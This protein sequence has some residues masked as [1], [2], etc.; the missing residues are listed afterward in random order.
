MSPF[1]GSSGKAG[2]AA[3][4]SFEQEVKRYLQR[5]RIRFTDNTTSYKKPDFTLHLAAEQRFFLEVKEKQKPYDP[6]NWP[7]FAPERDLLILDDLTVR[8]CLG[9]A[10]RAG[11]MVRDSVQQI[12]VFFSVVDLAL[13]PKLRVNRTIARQVQ[14]LKGKWLINLRNGERAPSV[15]QCFTHLQRYLQ[16]LPVILFEHHPCYGRYAGEELGSGGITR[17]PGHWDTDVRSTR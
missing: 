14:D 15:E 8:K 17:R 2:D 9:Y 12:Y 13:M 16:E 11:V 7:P 10:P 5:A 4:L 1:W 6:R 3:N